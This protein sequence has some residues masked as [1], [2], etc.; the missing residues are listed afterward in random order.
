MELFNAG[1]ST[2]GVYERQQGNNAGTLDGVGEIALL[3]GGQT[4]EAT[5][6]EFL[7]RSVMNFLRRS[8][9]L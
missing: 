9:S 5:G 2:F 3:L 7:P 6:E 1:G 8:T 4:G